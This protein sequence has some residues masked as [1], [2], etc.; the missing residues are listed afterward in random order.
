MT[1]LELIG[2]TVVYA[3]VGVA[4]LAGAFWWGWDQRERLAL[5]LEHFDVSNTKWH[6]YDVHLKKEGH[7]PV[8]PNLY[9]VPQHERSER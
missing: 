7:P 2:K 5:K 1:E 9:A 3:L 6:A 4:M 8:K